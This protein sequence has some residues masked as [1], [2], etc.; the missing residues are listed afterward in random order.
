MEQAQNFS[1]K[2][3]TR[4]FF[5]LFVLL[6]IFLSWF[7]F[8]DSFA[9]ALSG[10]DWLLHY[11]I[12]IIFEIQKSASFLYPSTYFCTY[13]PHYLFLSVIK[14]FWEYSPFYYY[15]VSLIFRIGISFSLFF[16]VKKITR[17]TLPA[18][19]AAIFFSVSYIGIQTTDWVFNFTHYGGI[20][21]VCIFFVLYF[22][23][24]N[25]SKI[26]PLLY[27]TLAFAGA[28]II[29]PPR[30]H[31]LFPLI[32]VAEIGW[33]AIEGKNYQLKKAG[34]RLIM[35]L[36]AY[37]IV[38]SSP[39]YGTTEY[40]L[41]QVVQGLI[42]AKEMLLRGNTAFLLNPIST[43]GNYIIPDLLWQKI[44]LK[45][46][47][48]LLPIA[49]IFAS[50]SS[51]IFYLVGLKRKAFNVYLLCLF[52]WLLIMIFIRRTNLNFYSI[53]Q[54]GFGL[55]GGY[56]IIFSFRLFNHLKHSKPFLAFALLLGQGWMFTFGLFH[57]LIAPYQMLDS[58]L[59]Y[60]IQQAAGLSVWS[61]TIF[62]IVFLAAREKKLFQIQ[63][64]IY[65]LII[66]FITMH[67]LFSQQ[68]LSFLKMNRGV[69]INEHLWN[70]IF[71][72]VP[73]LPQDR[74]TVFYLQYDNYYLAEWSLRFPFS[75]R[76]ALHYNITNQKTNP[77]MIYEYDKLLSMVAD[78]KALGPQGY[79]PIPLPLDH[80]Y[81]Y[82]LQNGELRNIT[83]ALREK[84]KEDIKALSKESPKDRQ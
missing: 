59:R 22:N 42:M 48:G 30:M 84:L 3:R 25:T 63:G 61:A 26:L 62:T 24:K 70:T 18:L 19:L 12:W 31:G 47:L 43:I 40:N 81:G 4:L 74:P 67:I 53:Y 80:V 72:D 76:G 1:T 41:S 35:I 50:L 49:L 8:K 23:A 34:I 37:K 36:A 54:V 68:Y 57:W 39:G 83:P 52:I 7:T 79:E 58:S 65:A 64:V 13:C 45:S 69:E 17:Q 2:P 66:A 55:I 10:D 38:F 77:F 32:L 82:A 14:H 56:T 44:P 73:R 20:I 21:A 27:A 78:G 15:L 29:S 28:L 60:S 71:R 51:G 9:T 33:W 11:T 5:F 6:V 75:S 16:M 46:L